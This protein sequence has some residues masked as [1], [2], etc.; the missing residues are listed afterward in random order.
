MQAAD[1]YATLA[2]EEAN[3]CRTGPD[4]Y[5]RPRSPQYYYQIPDFLYSTKI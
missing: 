2:R 3:I 4:V 1:A 5:S